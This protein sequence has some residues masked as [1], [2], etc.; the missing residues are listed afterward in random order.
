[1]F[2]ANETNNLKNKERAAAESYF[3]ILTDF[4]KWT[5]AINLAAIVWIASA[6]KSLDNYPHS[7]AILALFMLL[8]SLVLAIYSISRVFDGSS[9]EWDLSRS[10]H[11]LALLD[12]FEKSNPIAEFIARRRKASKELSEKSLEKSAKYYGTSYFN[13]PVTWHLILCWSL[14]SKLVISLNRNVPQV[15]SACLNFSLQNCGT[16]NSIVLLPS[17]A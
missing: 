11:S 14:K 16:I 12:Y 13:V 9:N 7:L 4:V 8:M 2:D 15:L 5:T 17:P 3:R 1:M 6:I 10:I